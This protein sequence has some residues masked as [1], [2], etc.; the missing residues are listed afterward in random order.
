MATGALE[1]IRGW[2]LLFVLLDNGCNDFSVDI[3]EIGFGIDGCKN[4]SFSSFEIIDHSI[5]AAFAF[6]DLAIF[7]PNFE[8]SVAHA[9]D[10][11]ARAFTCLKLCDQR[12]EVRANL[13]IA[14]G[15]VT[16]VAFEPGRQFDLN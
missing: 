12:L 6:L 7:Q 10:S 8:D 16:Q 4:N 13:A 15:K 5:A 2:N 11:I 9:S 14:L 3:R 1:A